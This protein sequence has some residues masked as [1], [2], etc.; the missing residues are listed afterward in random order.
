MWFDR[1]AISIDVKECQ[2]SMN[3]IYEA[4]KDLIQTEIDHGI[5]INRIIVGKIIEMRILF[6]FY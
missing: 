4:V 5:P 6:T 3:T 2:K 1:E